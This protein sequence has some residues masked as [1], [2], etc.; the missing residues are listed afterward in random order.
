M[1]IIL[2]L[3]VRLGWRLDGLMWHL[4]HVFSSEVAW[5]GGAFK[6]LK[7]PQ[8]RQRPGPPRIAGAPEPE[9]RLPPVRRRLAAVALDAAA[10]DVAARR[11]D[12]EREVPAAV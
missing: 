6:P 4:A 1:L 11:R 5:T 7:G 8:E 10:G 12:G 3:C 9:F 2:L